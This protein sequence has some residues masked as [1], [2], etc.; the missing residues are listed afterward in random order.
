MMM[1]MITI[2]DDNDDDDDDSD[3]VRLNIRSDKQQSG[4]KKKGK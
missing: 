4:Y 1:M 2:D 3:H